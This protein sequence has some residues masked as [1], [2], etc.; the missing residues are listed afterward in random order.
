MVNIESNTWY[1]IQ[2]VQTVQQMSPK[3]TTN[4]RGPQT[5]YIQKFTAEDHQ[6]TKMS[7]SDVMV[8]LDTMRN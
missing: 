3:D 4:K 2:N 1:T 7:E 8:T 6:A 5:H